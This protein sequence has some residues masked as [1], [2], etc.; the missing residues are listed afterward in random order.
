MS[1]DDQA[2]FALG[3]PAVEFHQPGGATSI[4]IRQAFPGGGPDKAVL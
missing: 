2:H 1:G 4:F 3:Q